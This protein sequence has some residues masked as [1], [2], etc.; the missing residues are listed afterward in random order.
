[1]IALL[2][3]NLVGMRDTA[4]H[5]R[6]TQLHLCALLTLCAGSVC[7]LSLDTT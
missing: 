7:M 1:M 6:L 2:A 3:D 5:S 4:A